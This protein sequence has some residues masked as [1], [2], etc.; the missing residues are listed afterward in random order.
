MEED[1]QF[2]AE[3]II[4]VI[5]R[6][7]WW[8]I[9][10]TLIG[11]LLAF[12]ISFEVR[13]VY[14]S[15]AFVLVEQP[16]IS[17]K[18]VTPMISDQLDTRL[19]TLKE[20]IL[21][22]SRLEPIIE[23]LGLYREKAG[24][25][26]MEDRVERLRKS[27]EVKTIRPEDY[28]PTRVPSGFYIMASAD[29]AQTAQQV[30][31]E[32]LSMFM[33]ENLKARQQRAEGTTDFLTAQLDESKRA[34]DDHD[35]KLAE[36]K[37]KYLGKLPTDEQRNLEM[38]TATRARLE[39]VNLEL[40]Q[41]QQ[42]K[43]IQQSMLSQQVNSR[44]SVPS[45]ASPSDLQVQLSTLRS[46]LASLQA[47]YT[48]KHPDV[49]KTKEQIQVLQRQLKASPSSA[50]TSSDK[51]DAAV[52]TPEIRQARVSLQLTEGEIRSKLAEQA[53]LEEQVRALQSSLQL[54]PAV[55]E[56]YKALTRDYESA[57]QFYNDLLN[58][59]TQAGMATDLERRQEGEQFSVMDAPDLPGKPSFPDRLKFALAGLAAGLALGI[60]L[61][62][63]IERR[64][65]FIRT[66]D[67]VVRI[68]ALPVLVGLPDI[69]PKRPANPAPNRLARSQRL[70]TAG[71]RHQAKVL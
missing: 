46:E 15:R 41:A 14:T 26:S 57:L 29:T 59:K 50:D 42:Q 47:R 22:R 20:Q 25:A 67:D 10:P 62:L 63:L 64:E 68:L 24:S 28:S 30:C 61:A 13:S 35:A 70:E 33:E 53:R 36:F 51:S 8:I 58:K 60:G 1:Q 34:L 9:V 16:K 52:D 27:I 54:S 23:R 56:Q 18:F 40:S 44:K 2:S 19:M 66:E 37:R 5:R 71:E 45:G 39:A 48:D 17:D 12:A 38:L 21:S 32:I 7:F 4:A 43:I 31:T 65:D 11:P 49:I 69:T 6:R 3:K 55:E